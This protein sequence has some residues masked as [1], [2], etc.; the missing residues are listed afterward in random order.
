MMTTTWEQKE[1]VSKHMLEEIF[2]WSET[3]PV[4]KGPDG[5]G[6]YYDY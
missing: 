2:K 6:V 4:W 1:Q 5:R 3:T